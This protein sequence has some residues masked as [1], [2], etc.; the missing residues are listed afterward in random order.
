[1]IDGKQRGI[2]RHKID[3]LNEMERPKTGKAM[4]SF[5][6]FVNFLRDYVPNFA[7]IAGP[8]EKLRK[9]KRIGEKEWTDEVQGAWDKVKLWWQNLRTQRLLK[10]KISRT[11]RCQIKRL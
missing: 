11:Q 7:L 8:L 5:L 9:V 10:R 1:M 2:D 6:G 4:E 3:V